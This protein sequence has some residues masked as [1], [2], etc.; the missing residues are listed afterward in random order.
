MHITLTK[1]SVHSPGRESVHQRG[2]RLTELWSSCP[3]SDAATNDLLMRTRSWLRVGQHLDRQGR[4]SVKVGRRNPVRVGMATNDGDRVALYAAK[5]RRPMYTHLHEAHTATPGRRARRCPRQ[6]SRHGW[7]AERPT[8]E[9]ARRGLRRATGPAPDAGPAPAFH[10]TRPRL[11]SPTA[12]T[13]LGRQRGRVL[14]SIGIRPPGQIAPGIGPLLLGTGA[15]YPCCMS[16]TR[17]QVYLTEHQRRMID[18]I[19]RSEGVSLAEVVR[20]ALDA[21][22]QAERDAA[23]ELASTFGAD[24]EAAAPSRNEWDRG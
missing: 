24:P 13:L 12:V 2:G 14:P 8:G 22:L 6:A 17:T 1:R 18:E 4:R 20:R 15:V 3:R 23:T 19:V 5:L 16:A 7:S 9:P 10:S 21:Y 11:A